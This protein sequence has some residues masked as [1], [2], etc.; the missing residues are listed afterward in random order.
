MVFH[1]KHGA[2]DRWRLLLWVSLAAVT[3]IG[4]VGCGSCPAVQEQRALFDARTSLK[5]RSGPHI[6]VELSTADINARLNR[7]LDKAAEKKI[8]LPGLGKVG[9]Y[10]GR[11]TFKLRRMTL[12]FDKTDAATL[13]LHIG[14]LK[15]RTNL[16]EF[17]MRAAAPVR[18]NKKTKKARLSFRGDMF[19]RVQVVPSKNAS[20]RLATHLR[21]L[22]PSGV[23]RLIPKHE[24]SKIARRVIASLSEELYS[25]IRSTVLKPIGE[26]AS[27]TFELPDV[28]IDSIAIVTVDE[29]MALEIRT[30]LN[31]HGLR[32]LR[33]GALAPKKARVSMSMD[34]LAELGNWAMYSGKIPSRY[35]KK[36]RPTKTGD[37]SAGLSWHG[38]RR[39]LK[40]SLWSQPSDNP[41]ECLYVQA[42]AEPRLELKRS[43]LKVGFRDGK[44]ESLVGPPLVNEVAD[45]LGISDRAFA[46]S[47]GVTTKNKLSI[48]DEEV[49][50]TLERVRLKSSVLSFDFNMNQ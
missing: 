39:P 7:Q 14:L 48:G 17:R 50:T 6:R 29:V 40:V 20:D 47:K 2:L 5:K 38:G 4:S 35:D 16:L 44:I 22:L 15:G 45:V 26:I 28:P 32:P 37:F 24:I 8:T 33:K 49:T 36:G 11:Y 18:L 19:E 23:R 1:C 12:K 43:R 46:Y 41:L 27:L 21:G 13:S 10:A 3:F 30:S 25:Q 31:A 9:R 34:T 42:G